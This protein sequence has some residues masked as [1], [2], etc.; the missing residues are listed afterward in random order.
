MNVNT[1]TL[2]PGILQQVV[3]V[4]QMPPQKLNKLKSLTQ[5]LFQPKTLS[6]LLSKL[7]SLL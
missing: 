2:L 6:R 5:I 7:S 3:V 4:K 1:D